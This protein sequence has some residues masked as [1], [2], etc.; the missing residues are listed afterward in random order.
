MVQG[1]MQE[2]GGGDAIHVTGLGSVALKLTKIAGLR[3]PNR[4]MIAKVSGKLLLLNCTAQYMDSAPDDNT[5]EA[6]KAAWIHLDGS[7]TEPKEISFMSDGSRFRG[8]EGS[9]QLLG[10]CQ[11]LAFSNDD[12]GKNVKFQ[13]ESCESNCEVTVGDDVRK[14][15]WGSS[16][17][18]LPDCSGGKISAVQL[19]GA[20]EGSWKSQVTLEGQNCGT[21]DNP[22][23]MEQTCHPA[24][25]QYRYFGSSNKTSNNAQVQIIRS[26]LT[27]IELGVA[28]DRLCGKQIIVRNSK[29]TPEFE[30]DCELPWANGCHGS[31]EYNPEDTG[32]LC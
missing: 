13:E 30:N 16:G 24:A 14:V 5:G 3:G 10:F 22:T 19:R 17:R 27:D 25:A 21:F 28:N 15:L 1:C 12:K 29:F 23:R 18:P 7:A 32:M 4:A 2:E 20:E 11:K 8:A 31:S 9:S 6:D 26:S